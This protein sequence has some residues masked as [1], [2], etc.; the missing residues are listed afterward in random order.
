MM[1]TLFQ[2]LS[3]NGQTWFMKS[4]IYLVHHYVD[5]NSRCHYISIIMALHV[6]ANANISTLKYNRET[7]P[8]L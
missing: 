3:T 6:C 4:S 7:F 8:H 2:N 1:N 5:L